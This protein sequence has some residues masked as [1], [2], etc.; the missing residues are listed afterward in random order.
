MHTADDT[1]TAGIRAWRDELSRT[2]GLSARDLDE[3]EDHLRSQ[4][5]DLTHLGLSPDEA[6]LVARHRLGNGGVVA[7]E[8]LHAHPERAWN[9]ASVTAADALGAANP[10]WHLALAL[11]IGLVAGLLTHALAVDP[12]RLP[13]EAVQRGATLIPLA[14]LSMFLGLTARSRDR[15]APLLPG[16]L[17]VAGALAATLYPTVGAGQTLVLTAT[18]LPVLILVAVGTVH[19]GARWRDLDAWMEWVR[20]LGEGIIFYVLTALGGGVVLALLI[21]MFEAIGIRASDGLADVLSWIYVTCAVGAILVCAWLVKLKK[22]AT[23]NVA[24]V[25][26]AL[27]TPVMTLVL[28]SYLVVVAVTGNPVDVDRSVLIAFDALLIVV[29]AIVLFTVSARPHD[30]RPRAL[31]L[32]QVVL[33]LAGIVVDVLLL[34]AM[35]GRLW[36]YGASPNKLAALV[37]NLLLLV[38]LVGALVGYL[39]VLRGGS[40]RPLERWQ[41]LALP[42]FGAWAGIV[43]LAFPPL[44]GFA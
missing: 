19:L 23:E 37:L 29:E 17:L 41:S 24:P 13:G 31:D 43:A 27:F 18:H 15:F 20:F 12:L 26:T 30:A 25:L 9:Q 42:V 7:E 10:P 16:L 5:E 36:E 4:Y 6:M 35:S 33:V 40:A 11:G 39:Q 2:R 3:L 21:A 28:V 8:Y 32:M 14:A 34:W 44:F 38:H 22:A 1:L